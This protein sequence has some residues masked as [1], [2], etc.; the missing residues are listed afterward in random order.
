MNRYEMLI[1]VL[2]GIRKEAAQ[3]KHV[4]L[5]A[6]DTENP[7]ALW[8]ARSRAYI[9]LYLKVMFGLRDFV[10][11]EAYVTDGAYDGGVDGYYIDTDAKQIL[12]IQSKLRRSESNFESTTITAGELLAVQVR[13]ILDG[14]TLDACGEPYNGKIQGLQRRV[15]EILDLG[16]YSFRVVIL[17]N[18]DSGLTPSDLRR[19]TDGYD[20]EVFDFARAY[21]ELLLPV[22]QG[23]LFKAKEIAISLDLSNKAAGSKISYSAT[24][25][26]FDCDITV[27]F[28]PILEIARLMSEYRNSILRYNPRSY[29]EIVGEGVNRAVRDT[30]L[31][32]KGNDFALL[33]NGITLIC[34]ESTVS[35]QSGRKHKAQF[36]LRNPQIINGGQTA[37]TL[38]LIYDETPAED[39]EAL[40]A[41]QEVLVKAIALTPHDETAEHE[42]GRRILIDRIS[43][44]TNS[45][46]AVTFADRISGE[47]QRIEAQVAV[48][49]RFGVLVEL[50][51]GEFG[52]G[53]RA[54]YID[55]EDLLERTLFQRLYYIA[56]RAFADSLRKKVVRV[57][58]PEDM[59][60][61]PAALDRFYFAY[62]VWREVSGTRRSWQVRSLQEVLPK[63][64]AAMVLADG[65]GGIAGSDSVAVAQRV[66]SLWP[67]Y[68]QDC[69]H[70]PKFYGDWVKAHLHPGKRKR[71]EPFVPRR[72]VMDELDDYFAV[73]GTG[74]SSAGTGKVQLTPSVDNPEP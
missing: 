9:H 37:Y 26:E 41:G 39:R 40:L 6:A 36:Y 50:K 8:Q 45:Q 68:L 64:Y 49:E 30:V 74:A 29:L 72:T 18:M 65:Q 60:G 56:N 23:S 42:A 3:A 11:R 63:I 54:G 32:A 13:R 62:R 71:N 21:K 43:S 47:D 61:N 5:Y 27:V 59:V 15:G 58:F 12:F 19:L 52:E 24:V 1:R 7:E 66:Q 35:E 55:R 73:P 17:A 14:E 67:A 20:A 16:R 28:V 70:D 51:R 48:Y 31:K 33:N 69:D 2:D 57:P 10:E 46:T 22:L 4:K 44:A 38:S 34:D 25:P 53:V